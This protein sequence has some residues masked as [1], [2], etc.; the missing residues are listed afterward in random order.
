MRCTQTTVLRFINQTL[1]SDE[2]SDSMITCNNMLTDVD[3]ILQ[4]LQYLS[5]F[6]ALL[7]ETDLNITGY[8]QVI[9]YHMNN[10]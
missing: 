6:D 4:D 8:F 1:S 10:I 2:C 5:S 7:N 9:Y 3:I